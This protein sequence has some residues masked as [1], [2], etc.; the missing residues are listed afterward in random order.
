MGGFNAVCRL[1]PPARGSAD[2]AA[3]RLAWAPDLRKRDFAGGPA[4]CPRTVPIGI[5]RTRRGHTS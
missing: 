3:D 1:D 4:P 5:T 2:D